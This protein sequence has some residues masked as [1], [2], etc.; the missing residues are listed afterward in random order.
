[1]WQQD[2]GVSPVHFADRGDEWCHHLTVALTGDSHMAA[3]GTDGTGPVELGPPL[4]GPVQ[5]K[6][7]V[8]P[9]AD[10]ISCTVTGDGDTASADQVEPW[11]QAAATAVFLLGRE[12]RAFAWEAILGTAPQT[13][14]SSSAASVC[15]SACPG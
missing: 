10:G 8:R 1:M 6:L 12:D 3:P 15:G 2:L 14:Q 4:G 11:R 5:S 9:H 7:L 13:P